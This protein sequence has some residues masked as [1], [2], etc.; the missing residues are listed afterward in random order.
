MK[1]LKG[2]NGSQ[3]TRRQV[4][5]V[6]AEFEDCDCGSTNHL[7]VVGVVTTEVEA[8]RLCDEWEGHWEAVRL[9][10]HMPYQQ[11]KA[12]RRKESKS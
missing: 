2:Q 11:N 7:H 3:M 1:V 10:L 6:L 9:N 5:V 12:H 4:Y 8:R